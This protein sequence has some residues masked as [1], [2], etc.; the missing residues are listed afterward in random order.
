MGSKS[1][2]DIREVICRCPYLEFQRSDDC[3]VSCSVIVISTP[4]P[5]LKVIC[6]STIIGGI[7]LL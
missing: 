4:L 7:F 2:S 1:R 6:T 5:E 3:V